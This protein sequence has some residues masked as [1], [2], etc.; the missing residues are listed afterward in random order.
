VLDL[1]A[2]IGAALG[3]YLCILLHEV[4]TAQAAAST[5]DR[6]PRMFGRMTLDLKRHADPVGTYILPAVFILGFTF[7]SPIVPVFGWGKRH[8][9]APDSR[10]L[11]PAIAGPAVTLAIAII[12][13]VA[14]RTG[15]GNLLAALAYVACSITVIELLPL[16]G[17]DGGRILRRFL[18]PSAR[19]TFD[20]LV[21]YEV[22]FLLVLFLFLRGLVHNMVQALFTLVT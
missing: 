13:G 6:T 19:S 16:P 18:S 4:A 15:G 8:A 22:L 9:L 12:A 10:S 21:K 17:R 7:S 2:G 20:D 3:F 11:L 1:P 5:G 14:V